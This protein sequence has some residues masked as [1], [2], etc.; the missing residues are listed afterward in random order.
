[1]NEEEKEEKNIIYIHDNSSQIDKSFFKVKKRIKEAYGK[2]LWF[3]EAYKFLNFLTIY[4]FLIPSGLFFIIYFSLIIFI[5]EFQAQ[6]DMLTIFKQDD[7]AD[8]IISFFY[9]FGLLSMIVKLTSSGYT[10]WLDSEVN[11]RFMAL[12]NNDK[13]IDEKKLDKTVDAI[14]KWII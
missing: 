6:Q 10:S 14:K 4:L 12:L 8:T 3:N 1:M 9:L 2:R 7:S 11:F 13:T 5:G